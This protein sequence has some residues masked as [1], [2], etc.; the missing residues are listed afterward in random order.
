MDH[1]GSCCYAFS[2]VF[3]IIPFFAS[4]VHH[5]ANSLLALPDASSTHQLMST[6]LC[7]SNT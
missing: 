5:P 4:M 7:L 6:C 2:G 1:A 3:I